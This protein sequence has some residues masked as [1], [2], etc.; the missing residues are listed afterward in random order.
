MI[1]RIVFASI[2]RPDLAVSEVPRIISKSR[3][4]NERDGIGGVLVFTGGDFVQVIEGT[5]ERV[6]ACWER[7]RSDPRHHSVEPFL[8]MPDEE[9]WFP[10]WRVGYLYD[11]DF[12]RRIADWRSRSG[13]M[14]PEELH[15]MRMLL[16]A[17]DAY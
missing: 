14:T 7:I 2:P 4:N 3:I 10:E 1:R 16:A 17:T 13:S 11:E 12:A 6:D 8:D 9:P 15:E 5:P